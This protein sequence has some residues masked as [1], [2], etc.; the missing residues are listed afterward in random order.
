MPDGCAVLDLDVN[1]VHTLNPAATFIMSLCDGT[2]SPDELALALRKAVPSLSE[3]DALRDVRR[4]L[5][6]LEAA[7]MLEPRQRS[8]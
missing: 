6:Q 8:K 1:A 5:E 3:A 4:T 2:R 7:Q